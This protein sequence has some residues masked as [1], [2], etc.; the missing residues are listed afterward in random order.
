MLSRRTSFSRSYGENPYI[1]YDDVINPPFLSD[2][3]RTP[4]ELP[5]MAHVITMDLD[6]EAVAYPYG[7]LDK[8]QVVNDNVGSQAI[9]V[10]WAS[11]T[12]SALGTETIA[13]GREI[14]SAT[15]FPRLLTGLL[16]GFDGICGRT[17]YRSGYRERVEH[18]WQGCIG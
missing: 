15:A 4:S 17:Y 5:A 3:P 13:G 10:L 16:P 1:G 2:G 9:V 8:V 18:T 12:A 11:G 7:T 6:G 14:G